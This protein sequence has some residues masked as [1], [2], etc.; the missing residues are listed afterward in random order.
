MAV[1]ASDIQAMPGLSG[2]STADADF[3]L[4]LSGDFVSSSY[5]PADKIDQA[6]KLWT[7]HA[8]TVQ[9]TQGMGSSGP[10]SGQSVGDVRVTYAIADVDIGSSA[11]LALTSWGKLYLS[12]VRHY[13]GGVTL[14]V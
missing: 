7:A 5:F 11:W 9:T 6:I 12:M 13:L 14:A 3:W 1:T 4:G 2:V 8:L 10:V